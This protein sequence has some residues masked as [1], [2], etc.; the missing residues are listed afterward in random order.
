MRTDRPHPASLPSL[1][2]L[3]GLAAAAAIASTSLGQFPGDRRGGAFGDVSVENPPANPTPPTEGGGEGMA[4][5][6]PQGPAISTVIFGGALYDFDGA[7]QSGG[8][9]VSV[10]RAYAG[11][12]TRIRL[13]PQLGIGL[14]IGYEGDF[15]DFGGDSTIT[16]IAG[17]AP[18]TNVT[19]VQIGGRVDYAFDRQWRASAGL[20]GQFSG[21]NSASAGDS[22][23]FGGTV[24]ATYAFSEKFILGGGALIATRLQEGPLVIP[25]IFID[26]Q[27]AEGLRLS[28]VAGPEAYPT[29]AGIEL[30]WNPT[31]PLAF[32][33]GG[34]YEYR[35]FR[36]DDSGPVTRAGGVGGEQNF[37]LWVRAEWRASESLRLDFVCGVSLFDQ[38]ELWDAAGTKLTSQDTDP[39]FFIGGFVAFRF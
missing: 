11:I 8:G 34:R 36:L 25:L 30:I 7:F 13:D 28:N 19:S 4:P 5:N 24:G 22:F 15:Y 21:E 39:S 31:K 35:Q 14:R 37:P 9:N 16:R 38:Y 23:T 29:G 10:A 6:I 32:G 20:F 3:I 27:I 33:I 26:W 1:P 12:G 2:S 18:W 17:G